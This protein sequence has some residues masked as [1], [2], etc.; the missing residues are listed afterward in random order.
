MFS[1][2][3]LTTH[4]TRRS[5]V[6]ALHLSPGRETFQAQADVQRMRS[7]PFRHL[8]ETAYRSHRQSSCSDVT[9][10]APARLTMRTI[11]SLIKVTKGTRTHSLDIC[12]CLKRFSSRCK[13]ESVHGRSPS[14]MSG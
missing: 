3:P 8:D 12:L 1:E 11:C 14:S 2:A 7:R 9:A 5:A 4:R 10:N 6:D 13:M